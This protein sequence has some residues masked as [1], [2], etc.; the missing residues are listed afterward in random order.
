M[1]VRIHAL[2]ADVITLRAHKRTKEITIG[3]DL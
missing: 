3:M 2:R 1:N